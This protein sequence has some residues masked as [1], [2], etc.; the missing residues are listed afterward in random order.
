MKKLIFAAIFLLLA[1]FSAHAKQFEI[2]DGQMYNGLYYP[3]IDVIEWGEPPHMEF[4]IHSKDKPIDMAVSPGEKN[5]KP[6][7]WIVYDLKFR[8]EKVCRHV[9]APSQFKDG[10]KLYAYIDKSDTDYDNIV[11]SGNPLKEKKMLPYTMGV[12]QPCSDEMASNRP[13]ANAKAAAPGPSVLSPE[14][15]KNSTPKQAP[16]GKKEGKGVGVDYE[17]Q[18][19]PFSF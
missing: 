14:P 4:H 11:F 17:T 3:L 16:S 10:M 6:V 5:G 13:D 12:Y 18:A 2:F 19:L 7:L 8:N 1:S 9:L 15:S